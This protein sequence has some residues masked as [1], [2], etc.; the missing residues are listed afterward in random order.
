MTARR[1]DTTEFASFYAAYIARVPETDVQSALDPQP[2]E[3]R[4]LADNID[5]DQ[6]LFRYAPDKWSVR[7]TFGHL[8]DTERV[9]GYRVLH[10][11][12]RDE[13]PARVR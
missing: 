9:M 5:P 10:F 11:A 4:A 2:A 3:L 13:A 8:I 6:E 12:R 7:Q 1:P